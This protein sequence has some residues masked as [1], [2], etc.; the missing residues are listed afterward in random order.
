[1]AL[2][3][4]HQGPRPHG[5]TAIGR[6][7]ALELAKI[8]V[9]SSAC[10]SA[11]EVLEGLPANGWDE[12][13][14]LLRAEALIG[15]GRTRDAE[16]LLG[17]PLLPSLGGGA[18]ERRPRRVRGVLR[19]AGPL[20]AEPVLPRPNRVGTSKAF[21]R[22]EAFSLWKFLLQ[23]RILHRT[24]RYREVLEFG[25]AFFGRKI[26]DPNLYVV[27]IGSVMAQSMLSLRR[28]S[29]A[30]DLYAEVLDL[31]KHLNSKEGVADSLLGIA[32]THLLDCH[33]DEADAVYQECR[34]RYEELGQS[35]KALACL[36]NLGILRAKRGEL[37][38]GR[39]LLLQA[40]ARAGQVGEVRRLASIHLG[41]AMV[42]TRSGSFS[43]ARRH[44]LL[45]LRHA[46]HSRSPRARALALEFLGELYYLQGRLEKARRTLRVGLRRAR[47]LSPTGDLVFEIRRRQA[48]VA[49]KQGRLDEA[50][51]LAMEA[52]RGAQKYGDAYEA[53][54][55]ERVLAEIDEAEGD[56]A[57]ALNRIGTVCD[58]LDRLGETFERSRVELVRLRLELRLGRRSPEAVEKRIGDLSRSYEN[59]PM[60][61]VLR[62]AQALA[63]RIGEQYPRIEIEGDPDT[64]GSDGADGDGEDSEGLSDEALHVAA[65]MGLA[66]RDPKFLRMLALARRVAPLS[67]PVLI[68]GEPGTGRES[69]AR[70]MHRWSGRSGIYIPFYCANLP[71]ELLESELFGNPFDRGGIRREASGGILRA[72]DHGTVLL[73]EVAALPLGVQ[74]RIVRWL[75]AGEEISGESSIGGNA[76]GRHPDVRIL[77]ATEPEMIE[78]SRRPHLRRGFLREE[79]HYRLARV[80]LEIP[81]LR[82]RPDD[83]PVL[84]E[85]FL[86]QADQRYGDRPDALPNDL[87]RMFQEH[88]WPNNMRELREAVDRYLVQWRE[89]R[90]ARP[91]AILSFGMPGF[92][93]DAAPRNGNGRRR[94]GRGC[95][96]TEGTDRQPIE[97]EGLLRRTGWNLAAT[98]RDLGMSRSALYRYLRRHGIRRPA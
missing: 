94:D 42:E 63:S 7:T 75:D 83:I 3:K 95:S 13:A 65:A 24:G 59:A 37:T 76:N 82:H 87:L 21:S 6:R 81:P 17:P 79:L 88:S 29:E 77:S 92:V 67:V 36:I 98:A 50:R 12:E 9:S 74:S 31:Y 64:G 25:R 96:A 27:R 35:D 34:F 15:L 4:P 43:E 57:T 60:S 89:S 30:R 51:V 53:A 39:A 70:L 91:S 93:A 47:E 33:W 49:L 86:E 84:V 2:P 68:L 26:C 52:S 62:E 38:S 78:P 71:G 72:T 22:R 20:A 90:S 41:L 73:D 8:Y 28:P 54:A 5:Q 16:E 61:P 19:Q 69:L 18:T 66:S 14:R 56:R 80:V 46:R 10:V 97:V 11:L 58:V 45:A 23:L 85:Q 1:M 48:E 40:L 32:N 55:S 44:I